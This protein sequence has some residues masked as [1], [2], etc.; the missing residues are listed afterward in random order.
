MLEVALKIE[1]PGLNFC[2]FLQC[3]N[4]EFSGIEILGKPF[5]G[6]TFPRSITSFKDD[7]YPFV[8]FIDPVLQFDQFYLQL[9]ELILVVNITDDLRHLFLAHQLR[10]TTLCLQQMNI[11]FKFPDDFLCFFIFYI[12]F[13]IF[14][15]LKDCF[16]RFPLY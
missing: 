6:S 3:Y 13:K 8:V 5:D 16:H 7:H 9:F 15:I 14:Q 4:P 2:R 12:F 10:Q 11:L 1:L